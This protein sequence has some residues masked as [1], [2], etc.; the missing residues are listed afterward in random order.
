MWNLHFV[1]VTGADDT[2]IYKIYVRWSL[3]TKQ[4]SKAEDAGGIR[5]GF[6]ERVTFGQ[7]LK[8]R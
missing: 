5:E 6:P 8:R 4:E 3:N 2:Y 1:G 7:E